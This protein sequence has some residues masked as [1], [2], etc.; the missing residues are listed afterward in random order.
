MIFGCSK[1]KICCCSFGKEKEKE[2]YFLTGPPASLSAHLSKLVHFLRTSA[3]P[4]A[5]ALGRP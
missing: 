4:P 3:S 2:F 1:I 5:R